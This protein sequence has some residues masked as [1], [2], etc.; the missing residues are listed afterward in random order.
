MADHY[1]QS[2]GHS[3]PRLEKHKFYSHL[4]L[5]TFYVFLI[6]VSEH[7]I[8]RKGPKRNAGNDSLPSQVISALIHLLILLEEM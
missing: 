4:I 5:K 1:Y 3:L 7:R 2:Q 6:L 8:T